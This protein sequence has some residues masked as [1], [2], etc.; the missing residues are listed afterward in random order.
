MSTSPAVVDMAVGVDFETTYLGPDE[1]GHNYL[2][3]ETF[4][5]RLKNPQRRRCPQ[6]ITRVFPPTATQHVHCA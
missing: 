6:A 3:R 1:S 2:L 4:A 5:V